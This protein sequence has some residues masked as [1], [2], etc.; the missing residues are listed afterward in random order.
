MST[1]IVSLDSLTRAAEVYN[2]VLRALP[3][4]TFQEAARNLRLNIL[5]VDGEHIE[6]SKRRKS[7]FLRAYKP[8]LDLGA[9]SELLKFFESKLKPELVYAEI[10]DNITNYRD[11]KVIS[12]A[13]EP[14][15][16]K[17]KKHP[18]EFLILR[19]YVI[20]L[21]EDVV[22]NMF[23]AQRDFEN[24]SA[25]GAFNGFFHKLDLLIANENIS[26]ENGNYV[27]TGTFD[28]DGDD[29]QKMVDF[30]R[31]G[32][33]MLRRAKEVLLYVAE[34]PLDA[35]TESFRTRVESH[36]YPSQEQVLKKLRQDAKIPGL[37]IINDL[38][39]GTGDRL[40]LTVPGLLDLG[41]GNFTDDEYIQVRNV[42][43][44]PN[45]V[46][47]WAQAAYD[48]RIIDIHQ[49]LFLTNEQ[50]NTGL[51]LAGD[52]VTAIDLGDDDQDG[53]G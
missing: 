13:G 27:T 31:K 38:A 40:M 33:P 28:S 36:D 16:N 22:F 35:V 44:D 10:N 18:L 43:K 26:A 20:S 45:E 7:N 53:E 51:D 14:I 41:V 49:K 5:Q 2:N 3:Y 8:G 1:K 39:L 15:N 25:E 42:E 47:F 50:K 34:G 12:N 46:Q 52:E 37:Q 30:L 48:T 23:H 24:K 21:A 19:D 6:I 11:K 32:H 9:R 29:Y 17:T 4:F